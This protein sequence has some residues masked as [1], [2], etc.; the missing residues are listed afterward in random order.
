[1]GA[2][3]FDLAIEAGATYKLALTVKNGPSQQSP[4]LDLTGWEPRMQIRRDA[5]ALGVVLDCR[6]AND[7]IKVTDAPTGKI[8]LNIPADDTARLDLE[9]AVYD[10]IITHTSGEV[11]RLLSGAVT[12][13]PAVT[14]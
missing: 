12:V 11:R 5:K 4:A 6:P 10:V 3:S 1:M 14:R 13:S 9:G 7:R 2:A 8:L